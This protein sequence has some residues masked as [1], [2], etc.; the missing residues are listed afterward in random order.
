MPRRAARERDGDSGR[1]RECVSCPEG[2]RWQPI[3]N[4]SR[5][6]GYLLRDCKACRALRLPVEHERHGTTA[7]VPSSPPALGSARGRRSVRLWFESSQRGSSV[8]V[9]RYWDGALVSSSTITVPKPS[10]ALRIALSWLLW[11]DQPGEPV[12]TPFFPS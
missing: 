4:F 1:E 3:G 11:V 7:L 2:Q 9:G 6:S 8:T 12:E 10:R 5:K